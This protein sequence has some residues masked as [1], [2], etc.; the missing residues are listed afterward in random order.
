MCAVNIYLDGLI[1]FLVA[2]VLAHF[3]LVGL[4][5]FSLRCLLSVRREGQPFSCQP[6]YP[7]LIGTSVSLSC[8]VL[9]MLFVWMNVWRPRTLNVWLDD[10]APLWASA[11][12]ALWPIS[13]SAVRSRL[14]R[15]AAAP[16]A[17][18]DKC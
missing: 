16:R 11:V 5:V 17:G 6:L 1:A 14:R 3:L 7:H 8:C 18:R 12:I 15:S 9:V 4:A 2:A 13:S 10:L